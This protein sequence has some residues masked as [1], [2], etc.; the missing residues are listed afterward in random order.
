MFDTLF[1]DETNNL[2]KW[3]HDA[4]KILPGFGRILCLAT[5]QN[6]ELHRAQ[7]KLQRFIERLRRACTG[8]LDG[9]AKSN[10]Q[11][12]I[13]LLMVICTVMEGVF[14]QVGLNLTCAHRY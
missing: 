3:V 8:L 7:G 13:S 12:L 10:S 4:T 2:F 9:E 11:M 1:A 14:K 5:E 6:D